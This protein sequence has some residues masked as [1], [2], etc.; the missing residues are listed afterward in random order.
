MGLEII[1]TII[2]AVIT[3]GLTLIGVVITNNSSHKEIENTLKINQAITDTKLE[4]LTDEVRKHN[5][6]AVRI[7]MIE[8]DIEF[9]KHEVEELKPE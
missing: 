3:G 9:L 7:P 5:N 1:G 2:T 4:S 6:F 8:K